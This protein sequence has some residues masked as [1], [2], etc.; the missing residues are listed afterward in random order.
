[1]QS[2]AYFMEFNGR[3]DREYNLTHQNTS[4]LTSYT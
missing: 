3:F 4:S 2:A 1:M